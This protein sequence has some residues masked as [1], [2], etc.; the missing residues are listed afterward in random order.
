MKKKISLSEQIEKI[1]KFLEKLA[2]QT[3]L[4]IN[5]LSKSFKVLSG[6]FDNLSGKFDHL[7]T[8]VSGQIDDLA[9]ITKN[10]F[11][12]VDGRLGGLELGQDAIL[13]KLDNYAYKFEVVD[14]KQRVNRLEKKTGIKDK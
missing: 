1:D 14:I 8:S 2:K 5:D 12:D 10:S 7:S 9:Q 6:R 4:Q 13:I 11:D 3:S